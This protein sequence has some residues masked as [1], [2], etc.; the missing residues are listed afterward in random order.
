MLGAGDEAPNLSLSSN[1]MFVGWR[2]AELKR[3]S[4]RARCHKNGKER[5]EKGL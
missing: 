3:V 4:L 5:T 1:D 2:W